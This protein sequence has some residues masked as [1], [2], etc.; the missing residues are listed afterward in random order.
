MTSLWEVLKT[1]K[2]TMPIKVTKEED[3]EET[4][5]VG[6]LGIGEI[7]NPRDHVNAIFTRSGLTYDSPVN[8]NAKIT[9]IYD[10]SEDE[11]DEVEKEVEY[12]LLKKAKKVRI[13]V[14]LVDVLAGM[15]NYGKFLKDIMSNKTK[16]EQISDAF[17]NEEC[18]AIV[19]NKLPLKLGDPGSFLIPCTVVGSV[20]YLALANLGVIINLMP[21]S[22]YAS[23]SKNTLKPTRMSI[24]LANHSYQYPMGIA[25]NMLVQVGKFLIAIIRVKNKELNLGVGDDRITFLI[26]KSTRHSYS[27][28]DTC[29][30][31]DVIDEVT[32]EEFDALLDEFEPFSTTSEKISESSLDYEFEEFMA[33]KIKEIPEQEEEV[34][35]NFKEL[36]L[37]ENLS[38][39][40][41]IQDSSNDLVIKPLPKHLEYTFLEKESLLP[42]VISTLLKDDEK[43]RLVSILKKHKEAFAWKTSDIP[44]ISP[45]FCKHKINFEDDDKPVIQRQR[46][47]NPNMKEVVKKRLSNY[48]AAT[49]FGG[50]TI[51]LG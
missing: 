46:R 22:L 48:S 27:N 4:T 7:G 47:L 19:Q 49:Q 41:S 25:E 33:I 23:L 32:E 6:V 30:R 20:E 45:S 1:K 36:P 11:V 43:K 9:V 34:E 21:Y 31:V 17:L 24:C 37:E 40:N 29:F 14:P 16:M 28:D 50:V 26:D 35:D 8:P 10:D 44:G 15:P 18:F 51:V 5:T 12:L 42:I 39:K 38:V 3:I 2:L 13:N